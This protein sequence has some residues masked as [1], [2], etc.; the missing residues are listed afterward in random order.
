MRTMSRCLIPLFLLLVSTPS[1]AQTAS[2]SSKEAKVR[3]LLEV[4]GASRMGQQVMDAM[5][6]QFEQI[7]DLPDGFL[8]EFKRLAKPSDLV[9]LIVPIYS[10]HV[11]EADIDALIAFYRSPA[12]QRFVKAQPHITRESMEAGQRWGESLARQVIQSMERRQ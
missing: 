6:A 9:D 4:S 3:Q 7:P 2:S 10:R 1:T 5:I 12:G 11:E 8:K